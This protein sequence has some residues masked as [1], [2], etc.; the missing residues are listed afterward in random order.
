[1]DPWLVTP[2]IIA[3]I[4][5]LGELVTRIIWLFGLHHVLCDTKPE[6]R[7]TILRAYATCQP[8]RGASWGRQA[9]R[10]TGAA[11]SIPKRTG[12]PTRGGPADDHN[13]QHSG[14]MDT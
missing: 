5:F 1:M 7:D 14:E 4:T 9:E 8:L 6:D 2:L 3:A 12:P 10:G 11:R 13:P